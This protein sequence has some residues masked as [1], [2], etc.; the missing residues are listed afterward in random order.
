M[1]NC[2]SSRPTLFLVAFMRLTEVVKTAP[3]LCPDNAEIASS[4]LFYVCLTKN[5]VKM[6][7]GILVFLVLL[8]EVVEWLL[9]GS[10]KIK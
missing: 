2:P 9:G 10:G 5:F 7:F 1:R 8:L 6:I 4:G 3:Y